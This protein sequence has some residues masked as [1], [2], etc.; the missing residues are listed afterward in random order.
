MV[1]ADLAASRD[2]EISEA[3]LARCDVSKTVAPGKTAVPI[4]APQ[5]I[6]GSWLLNGKHWTLNLPAHL[7][8]R[9]RA[10]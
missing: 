9:E 3:L 8:N 2:V 5:A 7:L 4:A 1:Y 6:G 10:D